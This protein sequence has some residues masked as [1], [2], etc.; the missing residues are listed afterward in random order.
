M[1]QLEIALAYAEKGI[2]VFP[3]TIKKR[4]AI[5]NGKGF[6][7]ASINENK[8]RK[9]WDE[10]PEAL[11]GAPNDQ[12]TVL[13]I[14]DHGICQAGQILT[15]A[16]MNRVEELGII[17]D[18]VMKVKTMSGGT[19]I[20]FR[21]NKDLRRKITCLPNIDLLCDGGYVILPDQKHYIAETET[22]W[23]QIKSLPKFDEK[24]FSYA[25]DEFE[26]ATR[27]AK[28]LKKGDTL[29][30]AKARAKEDVKK[31]NLRLAK[32]KHA[33]DSY[34]KAA[35]EVNGNHGG[36]IQG[37]TENHVQKNLYDH[38]ENEYEKADPA[39]KILEDGV[40]HLQE[41]QLNT[42]MVN[43]LFHNQEIQ[44]RLAKHL[45]LKP[46]AVGR[47]SLQNSILPN[48]RDQRASMGIRWSMDKT[49]LLIRDFSN[50][51]CDKNDNIDYNVVRLFATCNY[52]DNVGRM[53]P[54]EF[55]IWFL[56]LMHDAG[57]ISVK[58]LMRS[59][60]KD[61]KE[62]TDNEKKVAEEF[63]LLDALKRTYGGY[64]NTTTFAL[65]FGAAWTGFCIN[66]VSKIRK[67]LAEK[68]FLGF[69]GTYDAYAGKRD[70]H[71]F[72]TALYRVVTEKRVNTGIITDKDVVKMQNRRKD[73]WKKTVIDPIFG[74]RVN[75]E[76]GEVMEN[77]VNSDNQEQIEKGGEEMS[78]SFKVNSGMTDSEQ[79]RLEQVQKQY[80]NMGTLV[81]LNITQTSYDKIRNFM[82]DVNIE[83][84][85]QQKNM[86]IPVLFQESFLP[87]VFE[88]TEK[89]Y[90]VNRLRLDVHPNDDGTNSLVATGWSDPY[91]EMW[92]EVSKTM[93]L[94]SMME[95]DD[96]FDEPIP[97]F[98]IAHDVDEDLDAD[99]LSARF[100]R[101]LGDIGAGFQGVSTVFDD[102]DKLEDMVIGRTPDGGAG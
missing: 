9:W 43:E 83:T 32:T 66:T 37:K 82:K 15:D 90:F 99:F 87:E 84:P 7:D 25:I 26:E 65:R 93:K 4:P 81:R 94:K 60:Y 8:I 1:T 64:D 70:D 97:N 31:K 98:V 51:Y 14:D 52:K 46:T 48:H 85:V 18:G 47:T 16:A 76:T 69:A 27:T 42:A 29:T 75:K 54:A 50:F 44:Q 71:F 34:L 21:K 68:G 88:E 45:R 28:F 38:T 74:D 30:S 73:E 13:D 77:S 35:E 95:R 102:V 49:H 40:L 22:P 61:T 33:M 62:L 56:R 57:M 39:K 24:Q 11:V 6:K 89:T 63:L 92:Y 12:F 5:R 91:D 53:S 79:E 19:H 2:K 41:G 3:C 80:P 96:G 78:E 100:N 36:V 55:V 10:F 86:F 23:E 20:Y 67:N 101:Y 58:H 17:R 72:E 59:Y